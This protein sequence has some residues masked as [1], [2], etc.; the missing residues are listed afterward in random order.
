MYLRITGDDPPDNVTDEGGGKDV[1][2]DPSSKRQAYR[3]SV[4]HRWKRALAPPD[5]P[6]MKKALN[7]LSW[8]GENT[9]PPGQDVSRTSP[10]FGD[11]RDVSNAV[12]RRRPCSMS[13]VPVYETP[14]PEKGRNGFQNGGVGYDASRVE[15]NSAGGSMA[16]PC[17]ALPSGRSY[18]LFKQPKSVP[19]D[20]GSQAGRRHDSFESAQTDTRDDFK[21]LRRSQSDNTTEASRYRKFDIVGESFDARYPWQRDVSVQCD[22]S[23]WKQ[24]QKHNHPSSEPY[25][26]GLIDKDNSLGSSMTN[27]CLR[28]RDNFAN[29]G[30]PRP[31][32]IG[33]IENCKFQ[34]ELAR[35]R[36][37]YTRRGRKSEPSLSLYQSPPPNRTRLPLVL[38]DDTGSVS[39]L[40]SILENPDDFE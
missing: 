28:R 33:P 7:R 30:K 40:E 15:M 27:V 3:Y 17:N 10:D 39:D 35:F 37:G 23:Y 5:S 12:P 9:S 18:C 29:R 24:F 38:S 26:S 14:V 1:S 16:P 19:S 31:N 20:F 36:D 22:M 4:P 25:K 32:S 13:G 2:P 21:H 34:N 8:S 6:R 11:S